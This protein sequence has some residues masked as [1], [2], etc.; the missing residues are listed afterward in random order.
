MTPENIAKEKYRQTST[1]LAMKI[2][3]FGFLLKS[4]DVHIDDTCS[5]EV[6][7]LIVIEQRETKPAREFLDWLMRDYSVGLH[8]TEGC[9][10]SFEKCLGKRAPAL[11]IPTAVDKLPK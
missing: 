8:F 11:D 10:C 5:P 6:G 1:T 7:F 4:I 2:R 9:K 3:H